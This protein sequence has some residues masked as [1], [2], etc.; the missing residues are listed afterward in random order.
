VRNQDDDEIAR[1]IATHCCSRHRNNQFSPA[2][3]I[4]GSR[5]SRWPISRRTDSCSR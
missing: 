3:R 2:G 4:S 1:G 5:W